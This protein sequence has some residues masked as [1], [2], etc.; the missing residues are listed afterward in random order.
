MII[1]GEIYILEQDTPHII[2][3]RLADL[4]FAF[5]YIRI[6]RRLK[7]INPLFNYNMYYHK[8]ISYMNIWI[9]V[10]IKIAR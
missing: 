5:K 4:P 10:Y 6:M 1:H 2:I 8:Q 7:T 3:I 9:D